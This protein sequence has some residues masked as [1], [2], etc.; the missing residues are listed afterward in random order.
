[1]YEKAVNELNKA[2]TLS[3]NST[4]MLSG[5]GQVYGLSGKKA[6]AHK[7][8]AELQEQAKQRYVSPLYIAM[9]YATLGENDRAFL[10]LEK[11][12]QDH[13]P[14]LVELGIEPGWDKIRSDPRFDNLLGRVGLPK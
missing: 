4:R 1:M 14:W 2:V 6:E 9:V 13:T 3:G 5:L 12:Y 8:I 11:A 7:I 10:W